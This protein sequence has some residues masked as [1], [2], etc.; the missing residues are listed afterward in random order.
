[1]LN[2]SK[3]WG[4]LESS[5]LTFTSKGYYTIKVHYSSAMSVLLAHADHHIVNAKTINPHNTTIKIMS[6]AIIKFGLIT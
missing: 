1:V 3:A 6:V 4:E 5:Q 2:T